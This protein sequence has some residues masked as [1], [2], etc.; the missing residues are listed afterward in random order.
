ME[1]QTKA[2]D[3]LNRFKT[4]LND[5]NLDVVRQLILDCEIVCPISELKTGPKYDS[6]I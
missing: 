6:L 3:V 1:Y 4:A 5:N 2:D